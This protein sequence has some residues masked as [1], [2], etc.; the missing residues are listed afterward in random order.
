MLRLKGYSSNLINGILKRE[1]HNN[2]AP[3]PNNNGPKWLYLKIPYI[4]DRIDYWITKLFKKEGIP[5]R[6]THESTTLRQV[7]NPRHSNPRSCQRAECITSNKNLC[8]AKNCICQIKCT[9][10]HLIYIGSTIR[11]LNDRVK[12]PADQH[13]QSTNISPLIIK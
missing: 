12:E 3:Q 10:C 13:L 4:S 7:L 1:S 6:I 2:Q 8:F 5:V 11:N 9:I